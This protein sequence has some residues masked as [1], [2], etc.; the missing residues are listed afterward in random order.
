M[1]LARYR[2]SR[3]LRWALDL[4]IMLAIV[5]GF[6]AFQTRAHPRGPTPAVTLRSFDGA[7]SSLTAYAGKPTLVAIWAPWCGVCKLT[8]PNVARARDWLGADA[9]V[10]SVAASF[11]TVDEVE[12]YVQ[13]NQVDGPVLLG[14]RDFQ[15]A[16]GVQAFPSFFVLDAQG[17]IVMSAQGYTTT[18]G[19]WART[20]YAALRVL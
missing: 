10:I 14:D 20:R 15:R 2:S 5:L 11:R 8:A 4:A 16:L 7:S 17:R 9:H 13:E 3:A 19:L 6:E 1:M 12:R 18:F